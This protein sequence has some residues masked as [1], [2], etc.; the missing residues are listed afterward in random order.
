MEHEEKLRQHMGMIPGRT[1]S[2]FSAP[3]FITEGFPFHV[4]TH[5][6]FS[7]IRRGLSLV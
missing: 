5:N 2:V 1:L 7:K 6:G 3:T 4:A